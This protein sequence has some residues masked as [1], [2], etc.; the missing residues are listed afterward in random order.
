MI[1]ADG[2]ELQEQEDA[3][4]TKSEDAGI[5]K[6]NANNNGDGSAVGD[7]NPNTGTSQEGKSTAIERATE[8]GYIAGDPPPTNY[9]D[10]F[11]TSADY[12][13]GVDP[14]PMDNGVSTEWE[15]NIS[16]PRLDYGGGG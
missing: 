4:E 5:G 13:G 9:T 6:A 3:A 10:T 16:K 11:T 14:I 8:K 1:F 2:S 7:G 12:T 15:I